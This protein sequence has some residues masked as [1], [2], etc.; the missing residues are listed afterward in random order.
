MDIKRTETFEERIQRRLVEMKKAVAERRPVIGFDFGNCNSYLCFI[1]HYDMS[2]GRLGGTVRT[3]IPA[4][5]SEG[6]PSVFFY[7]NNDKC[8]KFAAMNHS[9]LPW[10]GVDAVRDKATPYKNRMKLLKRHLGEIFTLDN[11]AFSYDDAIV[12][13]VEHCIRT[14]NRML[15]QQALMTT[16]L[17]SLAYPATYTCAQRE[18]LIELVERA[19]LEDGT[20]VSV[21]GTITEP[22]AA[23][24]DYLSECAKSDKD[25]TVLTYDLGG[26]TFDL[27]LVAAYPKG[28]K[29]AAGELY[30]YDIVNARGIA[31]LGGADFDEKLYQLILKKIDDTL[32]EKQIDK[33]R[34]KVES[35]KKELS[36]EKVVETDFDGVLDDDILITRT[37]FEIA[38]RKQ[39]AETVEE[40]KR[41]LKEHSEQQPEM[42][43]LT[44]GASQMPIIQ[45]MLEKELPQ[46]KGKIQIF[47]PSESIACG[48]A[49]F[50]AVEL[51]VDP[52][53]PEM[54]GKKTSIIQ[55]RVLYDIGIRWQESSEDGTL[56]I[57]RQI[58]AGSPI[59]FN[60]ERKKALMSC[61][62]RDIYYVV[63]EANKLNPDK[64]N[65]DEDY[66]EIMSVVLS[67]DRE[68]PKG[69]PSEYRLSVDELGRLLIEVWDI[70]KPDA[71]SITCSVELKN[72]S[73][74]GN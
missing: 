20:H 21:F 36:K 52:E 71:P 56:F 2:E 50:G 22:A 65:I 40:T 57:N 16:N 33:L 70:S 51:S 37:E 67:Y 68:Q 45:E 26:G 24:L 13:V 42:I 9:P 63:W 74:G 18:K 53:Q 12:K 58:K 72:L 4:N 7:A 66:R 29:N 44:G 43:L 73:E 31:K 15:Q 61:N 49:R 1:P 69:T 64:Y 59:P 3:L 11:K 46:Y 17:V 34:K 32:N 35:I 55:Q 41:M 19:T 10:C 6:I 47:R 60:G 62:G 23:A 38:I 25:T 39:I 27:A 28:R 30:Y 8:N 54:E 5:Y 48:A 14:A